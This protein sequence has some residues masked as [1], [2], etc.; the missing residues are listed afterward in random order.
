MHNSLRSPTKDKFST[1]RSDGFSLVSVLVAA[2][3]TT[4]FLLASAAFIIPLF[5][6]IGGGYSNS[7]LLTGAESATD[8]VIGLLNDDTTRA[9]VDCAPLYGAS[10]H[11]NDSL[12]L[13]ATTF[14]L[15]TDAKVD[16]WV[17]NVAPMKTPT[18]GSG[19]SLS[20]DPILSPYAD[21]D[22]PLDLKSNSDKFGLFHG[23]GK[24][25][26]R[27]IECRVSYGSYQKLLITTL[28][29]Y[30][31][32][33]DYD[34]SGSSPNPLYKNGGAQGIN[35]VWLGSGSRTSGFTDFNTDLQSLSGVDTVTSDKPLLGGDVGSYGNV[36]IGQNSSVGGH[37]QVLQNNDGVAIGQGINI[38]ELGVVTQTL[39]TNGQYTNFSTD[40]VLNAGLGTSGALAPVTDANLVLNGVAPSFSEVA[41]APSASADAQYQGAMKFS[42]GAATI[43][44]GDYEASSLS[45]NS[46]SSIAVGGSDPVRIF[47]DDTSTGGPVV[48]LS[49]NV[50]SGSSP[51]PA[52]FQIFYNGTGTLN[53][54]ATGDKTMNATIYAPN[55]NVMMNA[56]GGTLKFSG[57][58]VAKNLAGSYT[59]AGN[60][61]SGTT[62]SVIRFD[63]GLSDPISSN[64]GAQRSLRVDV[65]KVLNGKRLKVMSVLEPNNPNDPKYSH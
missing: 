61:A 18:S 47:L 26:Y 38:D 20:Y 16:V 14:G 19:R 33:D 62:N 5:K 37:L 43:E 32:S 59:A 60:P 51:D 64:S 28:K 6:N 31:V 29:P 58:I 9:D 65:S 25:A 57:A 53:L 12:P 1:R 22:L 11:V 10:K 39:Q 45:V 56:T 24:N 35:S 21:P 44:G 54:Q 52:N 15:P 27:V 36:T 30:L 50:N 63:N 7:L 34:E 3:L 2:S 46:G 49:G 48:N 4:M 41:P 40:S 23:P 17:R 13:L 55:A 42:T 8:Y